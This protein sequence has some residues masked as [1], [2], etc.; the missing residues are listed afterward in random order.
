M[1]KNTLQGAKE[2]L[3]DYGA[4]PGKWRLFRTAR[5]ARAITS[6]PE[7]S[8]GQIVSIRF[9]GLRDNVH[10]NYRVVGMPV[11]EARAQGKEDSESFP[12]LLFACALTDFCL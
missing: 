7:F 4:D 12:T 6:C 2:T 9:F 8:V 10:V 1:K 11:Y 5:I 3:P